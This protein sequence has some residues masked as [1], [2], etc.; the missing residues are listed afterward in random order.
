MS[1]ALSIEFITAKYTISR[2][3][4]KS[5]MRGIPA[6]DFVI[7]IRNIIINLRVNNINN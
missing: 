6:V 5:I 7:I 3:N 4:G 2:E 1:S